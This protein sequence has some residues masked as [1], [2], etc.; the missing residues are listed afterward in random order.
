[1]YDSTA[2]YIETP[3][4]MGKFIEFDGNTKTVTVELDY[5]CRAIFPADTCYVDAK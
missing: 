5:S 3:G 2:G 4:G 1:M